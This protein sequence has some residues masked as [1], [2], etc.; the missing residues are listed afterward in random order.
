MMSS[1]KKSP[2][3]RLP[4][5]PDYSDHRRAVVLS[6]LREESCM[7]AWRLLSAGARVTYVVGALVCDET[8]F[9][10]HDDVIAAMDDAEAL[11]YALELLVEVGA[12]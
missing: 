4:R 10:A 3:I 2:L 7:P 8:G 1:P 6:M 11:R 12:Q 9:L 5:F